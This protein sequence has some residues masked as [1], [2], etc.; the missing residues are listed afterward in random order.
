MKYNDLLSK[1]F[2]LAQVQ[3]D[4]KRVIKN[5]TLKTKSNQIEIE[6]GASQKMPEK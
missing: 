3:T 6:N 5:S 4:D 1:H 2:A